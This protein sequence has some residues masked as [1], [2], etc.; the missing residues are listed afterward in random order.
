MIRGNV[1]V[2]A[3]F[4]CGREDAAT[5]SRDITGDPKA[6]NLAS[7]EVGETTLWRRGESP[8]RVEVNEPIVP[9]AGALSPAGRRF[10]ELVYDAAPSA[11]S[12]PPSRRPE[13]AELPPVAAPPP[14]PMRSPPE[15]PAPPDEPG[16]LPP[17]ERPKAPRKK[18][19]E[20]ASP[21]PTN[22]EDWLCE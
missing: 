10:V 16:A 22:L 15:S 4:R 20:P 14:L 11:A 3:I 5:L 21:R 2:K 17:A 1:G 18:P 19:Q 6:L 13:P 9:D 8:V 7:Q 12:A